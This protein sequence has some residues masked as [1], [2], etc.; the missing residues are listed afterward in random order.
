MSEQISQNQAANDSVNNSDQD[1]TTKTQY[2]VTGWELFW[3]NFLAGVSRAL[4][5]IFIWM[6]FSLFMFLLFTRFIWPKVEPFYHEYQQA[7]GTI[8]QLNS[9][10]SNPIIDVQEFDSDSNTNHYSSS[11]LPNLSE[12]MAD[13]DFQK[14][15]QKNQTN[16]SEN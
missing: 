9:V 4:G 13:P 2:D 16:P 12:I 10:R 1:S 8:N 6:I 11:T 15:I 14:L 3:R 5:G 7:L